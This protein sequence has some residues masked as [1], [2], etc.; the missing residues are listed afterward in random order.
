MV[1]T[2]KV[3]CIVCP[4]TTVRMQSYRSVLVDSR[5]TVIATLCSSGGATVQDVSERELNNPTSLY[6]YNIDRSSPHTAEEAKNEHAVERVTAV[7]REAVWINTHF[8]PV[9]DTIILHQ[10][11][12]LILLCSTM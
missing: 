4:L 5:S 7:L 9:S 11:T 12:A 10:F 8:L 2:F 1:Q 6:Y 3:L